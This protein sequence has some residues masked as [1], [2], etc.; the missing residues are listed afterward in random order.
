MECGD[1]KLGQ[2][3]NSTDN[4]LGQTDNSKK[5]QPPH[6]S[7]SFLRETGGCPNFSSAYKQSGMFHPGCVCCTRL[8][9]QIFWRDSA[10][11]SSIK[12]PRCYKY[13]PWN[14]AWKIKRQPREPMPCNTATKKL[15]NVQTTL[16]ICCYPQILARDVPQFFQAIPRKSVTFNERVCWF[17]RRS[18]W[19]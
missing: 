19:Y 8:P 10:L 14:L 5:A 1:K 11:V 18:V 4:L 15:G 3:S 13:P 16:T 2:S 6:A 17:H 7:L 12:L 9:V